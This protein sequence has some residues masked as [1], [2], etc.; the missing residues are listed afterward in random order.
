MILGLLRPWFLQSFVRFD[1]EAKSDFA[2]GPNILCYATGE[3]YLLQQQ[4]EE[5]T[6]V[7]YLKVDFS[8]KLALQTP[9]HHE[10]GRAQGSPKPDL[11]H[12]WL[13]GQKLTLQ[14]ANILRYATGLF[15]YT[16]VFGDGPRNFEP[17]SSDEDD[18]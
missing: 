18:T 12:V 15:S 17:W 14:G 6:L 11:R 13:E 3:R 4:K 1:L 10:G 7:G 16:R 8:K 5:Q 9:Q 2:G